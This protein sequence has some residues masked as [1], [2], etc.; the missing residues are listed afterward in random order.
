MLTTLIKKG[1][2]TVE[3]NI[4]ETIGLFADLINVRIYLSVNGIEVARYA[5]EIEAA[6]QPCVEG[7][8]ATKAK[9]LILKEDT[10]NFPNGVLISEIEITVT[11]ADY[12]DGRVIRCSANIYNVIPSVDK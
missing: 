3:F 8:T 10:I 9:I 12:I 4:P 2:K 11:D 6:F 1:D 5:K 7:S